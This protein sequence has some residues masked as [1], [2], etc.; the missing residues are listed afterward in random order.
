MS[1]N[2]LS[3]LRGAGR[4][5]IDATRGITDLVEAVHRTIAGVSA[6]IGGPLIAGATSGITTLVYQ[7]IRGITRAV[8]GG[9]D[10]ALGLL[11]PAM[12]HLES[13]PERDALVSALNGVLGDYLAATANPLALT[14][15]LR[16]NGRALALTPDAIAAA[17]P[18][19]GARILVLAHGLCMNDLQWNRGGHDHGVALASELGYTPVY[20]RYN[21]GLHVSVNGRLL[22][23]MLEALLASWPVPVTGISLVALSMG[24]LVARSADVQARLAGHAWPAWLRAM[25]FLGT[26][27]H[28]APLERIG[29]WTEQLLAAT[30]YTEPFTRLGRVRSAG[31]TDLRHGCLLEDD[32]TGHDRFAARKDPR[33]PMPLP[34]GVACHAV[35]ATLGRHAASL[36]SRVIGDG[37]VP[38][39]SA[40][41]RH[42]D[43][44]FT[45][46]FP[47]AHQW[48]AE[49]ASHLDLLSRS[50]VYERLR[51]WLRE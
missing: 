18:A 36:K 43:P 41:G 51:S 3:D 44:R 2:H 13:P 22:A 32:W 31:I 20:L 15:T 17:M 50:D 37:L 1:Q 23:D 38:V 7:S 19:A 35:A 10:G 25:V 12:G 49:G 6:P 21:S 27:H 29:N 33:R 40:L 30:P 34:D 46:A 42:S 16:R 26:P 24:G 4:I 28:G 48:V 8:G 5:A 11:A 14:M 9:I 47:E 39:E 45:L